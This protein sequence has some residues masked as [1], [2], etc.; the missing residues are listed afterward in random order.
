MVRQVGHSESGR[1]V[2]RVVHLM[3]GG[4]AFLGRYEHVPGTLQTCGSGAAQG[5]LND[6]AWDI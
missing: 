6:I 3:G 2:F 5:L 1:V 4:V